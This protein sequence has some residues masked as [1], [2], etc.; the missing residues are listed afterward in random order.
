MVTKYQ[1][2][3]HEDPHHSGSSFNA[4]K[5]PASPTGQCLLTNITHQRC[6]RVFGQN[7][8]ITA[9]YFGL[10]N[11]ELYYIILSKGDKKC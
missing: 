1:N 7:A 9:Y 5:C 3:S 8:Q 10:H 11:I 6:K 2:V 4:N